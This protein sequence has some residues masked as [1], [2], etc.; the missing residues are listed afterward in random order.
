MV[1]QRVVNRL[2]ELED[3]T[4]YETGP[5]DE[6]NDGPLAAGGKAFVDKIAVSFGDCLRGQQRSLFRGHD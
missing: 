1:S 4:G 3:P 5:G 6:G 2:E